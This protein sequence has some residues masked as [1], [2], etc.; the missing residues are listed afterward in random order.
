MS[1]K[2]IG[3]FTGDCLAILLGLAIAAPFVLVLTMPFSGVL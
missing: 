1:W 2:K 3:I